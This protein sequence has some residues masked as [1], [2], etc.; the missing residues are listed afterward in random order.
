MFFQGKRFLKA[1]PA[2]AFGV[3]ESAYH[4]LT[5]W[6]KFRRSG[7]WPISLYGGVLDFAEFMGLASH[8]RVRWRLMQ[9]PLAGSAFARLFHAIHVVVRRYVL[10]MEELLPVISIIATKPGAYLR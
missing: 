1:H 5:Y 9:L 10:V 7:F 3:N 8:N 6:W 2:A 4:A